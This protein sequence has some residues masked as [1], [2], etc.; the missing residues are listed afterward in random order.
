MLIKLL[1]WL[2][3]E[4]HKPVG[5]I[6]SILLIIWSGVFKD[7]TFSLFLV[8]TLA[9]FGIYEILEDINEVLVYRS[10]IKK[11][12]FQCTITFNRDDNYEC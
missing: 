2:K 10:N 6:L 1:K 8:G 11:G 3:E 12:V 5:L 4:W 9:S 7:L